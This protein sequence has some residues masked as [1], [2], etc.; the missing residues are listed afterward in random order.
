MS[1]AMDVS[2][3]L[4]KRFAS[5]GYNKDVKWHRVSGGP[6]RTYVYRVTGG[7]KKDGT[8]VKPCWHRWT[9]QD[10]WSRHEKEPG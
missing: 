5:Y 6:G 8:P 1:S 2:H 9:A 7:T 4:L 3:A 10:G